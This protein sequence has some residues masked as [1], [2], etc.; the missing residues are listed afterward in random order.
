M[1]KVEQYDV[2]IERDEDGV[3][4][5]HV[6]ELPGCHTQGGSVKEVM[7]NIVEAIELYLEYAK[8]KVENPMELIAV[9]KVAVAK[10]ASV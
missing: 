7:K 8:D 10:S 6:P 2:I 5:A 9:K 3:F 4:V 1:A